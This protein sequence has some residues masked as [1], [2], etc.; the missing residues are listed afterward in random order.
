MQGE[1]WPNN[2]HQVLPGGIPEIKNNMQENAH[3]AI[4]QGFFQDFE[5]LSHFCGGSKAGHMYF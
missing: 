4:Q 2:R 1:G 3:K 5:G